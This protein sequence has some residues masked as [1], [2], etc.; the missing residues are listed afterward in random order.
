[1]K[2]NEEYYVRYGEDIIPKSSSMYVQ[3]LNIILKEI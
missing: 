3:Y 1:M 2:K